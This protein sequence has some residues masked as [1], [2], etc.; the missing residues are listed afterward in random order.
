MLRAAV[1]ACAIATAAADDMD[2][3][4]ARART[5]FAWP[6]AHFLPSLA[7]S[8][9]ALAASLNASC[10][11]PDIRY[12]D[13]TRA[14]WGAA[15]HYVRVQTMASAYTAPGSPAFED[16]KLGVPLHCA[17]GVWLNRSPRFTN[18]NWCA[19]WA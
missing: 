6:A 17:L 2:T 10:Y 14:N 11:W 5:A 8:A 4:R 1:F 3:V 18:P 15:A 12:S 7:A 13:Q 19:F 9:R 16:E